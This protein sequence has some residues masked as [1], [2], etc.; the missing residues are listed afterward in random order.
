MSRL[1]ASIDRSSNI[2][3]PAQPA[4]QNFLTFEEYVRLNNLDLNQENTIQILEEFKKMLELSAATK[5]DLQ[6][7]KFTSPTK[8]LEGNHQIVTDEK[9]ENP[10]KI[11]QFP[12]H[13]DYAAEESNLCNSESIEHARSWESLP[14]VEEELKKRNLIDPFKIQ[15]YHAKSANVD[16]AA[17]I[18]QLKVSEYRNNAAVDSSSYSPPDTLENDMN[19]IGLPWASAMIKKS[20][21]V[22]AH[23]SSTTSTSSYSVDKKYIAQHKFAAQQPMN[24][25]V[26][27]K[28]KNDISTLSSMSDDNDEGGKRINLKD[29]LAKELLKRSQSSNSSSS[30]NHDSSLASKFLRSLLGSSESSAAFLSQN[31]TPGRHCTSTPVKQVSIQSPYTHGTTASLMPANRLFSGESEISSVRPSS[32][33][34]SGKDTSSSIGNSHSTKNGFDL[35]VPNLNLPTTSS[36]SS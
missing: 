17:A 26:D 10:L 7:R 30:I 20:K 5:M 28:L 14:N 2:S 35:N 33:S 4:I 18:E 9:H 24:S 36:L 8:Y 6:F 25:F 3:I 32:M 15:S 22:Q 27:S 23:T 12:S 31:Q 29:F 34:S 1:N 19:N 16:T 21:E 11:K 13:E